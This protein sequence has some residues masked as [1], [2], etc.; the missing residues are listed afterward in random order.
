MTRKAK[1]LSRVKSYLR[2]NDL[3]ALRWWNTPN[4][5][6]KSL[7]PAQFVSKDREAWQT[8]TDLVSFSE[9]KLDDYCTKD[10]A[11]CPVCAPRLLSAGG[12]L[13]N[14]G[15]VTTSA[16]APVSGTVA[17]PADE[18]DDGLTVQLMTPS[19]YPTR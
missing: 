10:R 11:L 5:A 4:H 16:A 1:I 7:T 15:T 6:L 9:Q 13:L 17:T 12:S 8:L 14:S 3:G 2:I 18:N 19:T